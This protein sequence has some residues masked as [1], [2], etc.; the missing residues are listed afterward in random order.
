MIGCNFDGISDAGK[1]D[2][3]VPLDKFSGMNGKQTVLSAVNVNPDFFGVINEKFR[4]V[5]CADFHL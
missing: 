3:S 2:L 5:I 4:P 1:I